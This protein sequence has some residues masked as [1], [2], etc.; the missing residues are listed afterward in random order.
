MSATD[1][2]SPIHLLNRVKNTQKNDATTVQ[3]YEN[4]HM[5][6]C[7]GSDGK[8]RLDY[9]KSTGDYLPYNLCRRGK[10]CTELRILKA[11]TVDQKSN[12]IPLIRDYTIFR[13]F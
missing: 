12:Q 10:F 9:S 13:D 1:A 5:T 3:S 11:S 2:L 7:K 4:S 8:C 6:I